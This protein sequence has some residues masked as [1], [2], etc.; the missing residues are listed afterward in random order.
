MNK[1]LVCCAVV[2]VVS[3]AGADA[4]KDDGVKKELEQFTGTWTAVSVVS[5]GKEVDKVQA[6][7]NILVV[8]GEKYTFTNHLFDVIEGTHELDP[9]KK[10][11]TIDAVRT[12]GPD[13]GKKIRGIYELAGDTYK[14][15]LAPPGKDRPKDFTSKPDSGNRLIV[16][17]RAKS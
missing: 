11:K 16:F 9:S 6:K 10:P 17:K 14:V 2:A 12:K 15:C 4:P 5:D 1:A 7:M 3:L 8:K 13:K